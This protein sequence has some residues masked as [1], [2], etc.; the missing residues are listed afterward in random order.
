MDILCCSCQH[1]SDRYLWWRRRYQT[2]RWTVRF[3]LDQYLTVD[4]RTGDNWTLYTIGTL[5]IR[6]NYSYYYWK[7]ITGSGSKWFWWQTSNFFEIVSNWI[8]VLP[9]DHWL[10]HSVTGTGS[11]C[12][13]LCVINVIL[14][15]PLDYGDQKPQQVSTVGH[16][17]S[18]WLF[19]VIHN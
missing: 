7:T 11:Y 9:F 8:S 12:R 10:L 4:H 5:S 2:K 16:F 13:V 1:T 14:E 15:I 6:G 17:W 18:R 3:Q 19:T